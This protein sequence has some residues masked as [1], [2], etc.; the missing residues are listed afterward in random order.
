MDLL[1]IDRWHTHGSLNQAAVGKDLAR[2]I[3][4]PKAKV[5]R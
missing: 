3:P 2:L 4:R 1:E 5:K